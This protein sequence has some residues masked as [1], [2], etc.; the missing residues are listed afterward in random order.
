M[1]S[2]HENKELLRDVINARHSIK[3][4]L[5]A[6]K[7]S[8]S[9]A[10]LFL[11][12]AFKPITEPLNKLVKHNA[13]SSSNS[14][15]DKLDIKKRK[16]NENTKI[17]FENSITNK[18]ETESNV[19]HPF[20]STPQNKNI[21]NMDFSMLSSSSLSS[22]SSAPLTDSTDLT[23]ETS[24]NSTKKISSS[25]LLSNLNDFGVEYSSNNYDNIYG[26]Y[27][28]SHN[29]K[30]MIGN[31]KMH[32]DEEYI[33]IGKKN[34][35]N[36]PGLVELIFRKIPDQKLYTNDDEQNYKNI[37]LETNAYRKNFDDNNI[38]NSNNSIKY[39][40][41]IKKLIILPDR[42][43]RGKHYKLGDGLLNRVSNKKKD[44]VYYDDCNELVERL[45]LL[46]ASKAAGNNAHDNEINSIIEEL[47]ESKIIL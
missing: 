6:L 38:V 13:V 27:I 43:R 22:L 37:L 36:T 15:S 46:V 14:E 31:K 8:E 40:K 2:A 29:K 3:R 44:Y 33:T 35:I 26:P 32:I 23:S 19:K 11:S 30:L 25:E 47:K 1:T 45:K 12:K 16:F 24:K 41:L 7:S 21:K 18:K 20:T 5:S 9:A 39:V 10:D 4:K 42:L 28:N 34:Y 17:K